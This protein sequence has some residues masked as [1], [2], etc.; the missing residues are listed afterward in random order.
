MIDYKEYEDKVR[1]VDEAYMQGI[2]KKYVDRYKGCKKVLD[3]ACGRGDFLLLAREAGIDA[4]GIDLDQ[5]IVNS[6]T[7]R[8][9]KVYQADAFEFLEKNLEG[10]D[11]IFCSQFIEHLSP[12]S[13]MRFLKLVNGSLRK[14]GIFII[15]TPNPRSITVH[16]QSFYK[17]FSHV[18]FYDLELIKFMA[19]CSGFRI[20]E[21]GYDE[22][23]AISVPLM[24]EF[25]TVTGNHPISADISP[26]T[27]A[28]QCKHYQ[29]ETI[30]GTES[31]Q[32]K[33]DI[34]SGRYDAEKLKPVKVK[35]RINNIKFRCEMVVFKILKRYMVGLYEDI[36]DNL[37]SYAKSMRM[38]QEKML[39][40]IVEK[41]GQDELVFNN[42]TAQLY[43][44]H[45]IY[46]ICKK[47]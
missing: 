44:P 36:N 9:L 41:A 24:Q 38:E 10:F 34:T 28:G 18:R 12:D 8:G 17:D 33:A 43:S 7:G 13:L 19:E 37:E 40:A 15:T 27:E 26:C 21:S 29:P 16:L 22:D 20:I 47:N 35:G 31:E 11:G 5:S 2:L 1:K 25:H 46:L 3:I 32:A 4:I 42:F 23:T 30:T 14:D 45:D 6:A 39:R